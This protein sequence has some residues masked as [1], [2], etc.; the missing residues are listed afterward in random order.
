MLKRI[1]SVDNNRI[2]LV[3]K[4]HNKKT[5][6]D[7]GKF[8][9]EGYNLVEEAVRK[10]ISIDFVLVA[11]DFDASE[12]VFACNEMGM[13]DIF[14]LPAVLLDKLA[15][16]EN[17]HGIG[18]LAVVNKP[19]SGRIS[20]LSEA[21]NVLVF[22]RI[23]DPGNLGTMI[24]TA[25]AAGYE[26]VI[27]LKGTADVFSAKVL[28]ST[29]GMIFDI[30]ILSVNN[31]EEL[32]NLLKSANKR[33]VVTTPVGGRPYYEEK[34]RDGIALVIGNEGNGISDE[35]LSIADVRVNIPM[36]GDIESLNAAVSAAI[37]MY[38]AVRE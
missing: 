9:I 1:E 33:I 32:A 18:I 35:I 5:R 10:N 37:L 27:T 17:G 38:E 34:L 23:Q 25:V 11:E 16:T 19:D 21:S 3:R 8:V 4:L 24:R 12:I 31:A 20:N 7:I 14:E 15:Q 29:A 36:R 2:K 13:R 28:R 6:D 30:P 26:M 22:D